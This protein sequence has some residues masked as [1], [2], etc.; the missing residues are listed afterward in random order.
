[1]DLPNRTFL[2]AFSVRRMK[3]RTAR[4][5][6]SSWQSWALTQKSKRAFRREAMALLRRHTEK[7]AW[8]SWREC[9]LV[10]QQKGEKLYR[11]IVQWENT[12]LH[13]TIQAWRDIWETNKILSHRV[14]SLL[15]KWTA[16]LLW[17]TFNQWTLYVEYKESKR[18]R[19]DLAESYS[20]H[21]VSA[22]VIRGWIWML[23]EK[24]QLQTVAMEFFES[25]QL[26]ARRNCLKQWYDYRQD[27][28]QERKTL[29]HAVA[30]SMCKRQSMCFHAW[31]DVVSLLQTQKQ[32][33]F[34][35]LSYS[36]GWQQRA[37]FMAWRQFV[38][39]Q[40]Q[41]RSQI[42]IYVRRW[43]QCKLRTGLLCFRSIAI[44]SSLEL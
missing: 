15:E 6:L 16:Q 40:E 14:T 8:V 12:T 18:A 32:K 35:A 26:R 13:K 36:V 7:K 37:T 33:W 43:Q 1:M 44:Q 41:L 38:V 22:A 17:R 34:L 27:K 30:R 28:E 20:K 31:R 9:V 23:E 21:L 5:T 4:L 25:L 39:Y 29:C 10:G 42:A 11:A 2:G 3:R 19:W 24:Q